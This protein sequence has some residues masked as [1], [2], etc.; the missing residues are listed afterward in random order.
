MRPTE[1][2][3]DIRIAEIEARRVDRRGIGLDRCLDL[4]D[5][6]LLGVIGLL[7]LIAAGQELREALEIRLRADEL[8]LVLLLGRNGLVERGLER[9]RIDLEQRIVLLHHLTFGEEDL[10]DLPVDAAAHGYGIVS[11][12][13]AQAV[14][15]DRD[16]PRLCGACDNR[17]RGRGPWQRGGLQRRLAVLGPPEPAKAERQHS[18]A[19]EKLAHHVEGF[20][21]DGHAP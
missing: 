20:R 12:H 16:V 2:R 19:E 3:A 15:I 7:G 6:R 4:A 13:R 9:A 1:R 17:H 14:G 5:Q 18:G 10:H 11:L 21:R 8:R